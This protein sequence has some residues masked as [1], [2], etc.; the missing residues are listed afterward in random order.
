VND[1][2]RLTVSFREEREA[3]E[4][5]DELRELEVEGR[6]AFDERVIVSRDGSSVYVYGD[7]EERLEAARELLDA[8]MRERSLGG[9]V[10]MTRWHPVEQSWEDA[11]LPLPR[12]PAEQEAERRVRLERE[13]EES[14]ESG[15]AEWEVRIE[16]PAHDQ[17][18]RLADQL[19]AEGIPVVRRWKFLLVGAANEDDARALAERLRAEAPAGAD[20]HVEPGGE[21]V[22][23]VAPR[24]PFA[25]FGGLGL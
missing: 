24:N 14:L 7:S 10:R 21:M 16:L 8:A 13:T 1:D 18:V 9:M 15:Y 25:I 5:L 23:E 2:L 20:V 22:W 12:T 17:T 6:G 11:E 4:L 19:E 3:G